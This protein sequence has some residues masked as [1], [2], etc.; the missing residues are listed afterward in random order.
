MMRY[1]T[2]EALR[3]DCPL[4]EGVWD[5][6]RLKEYL[7]Q[8]CNVRFTRPLEAFFA[9]YR[10]D[11]V[12]ADLLFNFLLC[13]DYDGSDCQIGAAQV[14]R[15]LDRAVLR[16]KRAQVLQAQENEVFWKRPFGAEDDLSW[17]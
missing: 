6:E 1:E 13:D 14:I 16:K 17:L 9:N 12:L 4:R 8:C 11:E 15:G 3:Q 2:W 10:E 7:I 5:R